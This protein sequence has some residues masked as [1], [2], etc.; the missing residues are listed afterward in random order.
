MLPIL[1]IC[2]V[3]RIA[4]VFLSVGLLARVSG[5]EIFVSNG[6]SIQRALDIAAPGDV[7]TIAAGTYA[8]S[9]STA[10]SGTPDA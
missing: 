4:L 5:G 2:L 8:E 10:R 7:V 6:G 1:D 3:R 9:L